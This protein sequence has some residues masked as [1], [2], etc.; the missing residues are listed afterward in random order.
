MAKAFSLAHHQ[1]IAARDRSRLDEV[2]RLGREL[3]ETLSRVDML[4]SQLDARLF[5]WH[6]DGVPIAAL[7][8]ASRLSRQTVYQSIDRYRAQLTA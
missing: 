5:Y 6:E 8:R 7:A 2:E 3:D 1:A 4:R